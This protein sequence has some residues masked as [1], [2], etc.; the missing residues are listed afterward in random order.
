MFLFHLACRGIIILIKLYDVVIV[1]PL[2]IQCDN[3]P[4]RQI[5]HFLS[6]PEG[7]SAARRPSIPADKVPIRF[8]KL[9]RRQIFLYIISQLN[10]F[11]RSAARVLIEYHSVLVCFPLRIKYYISIICRWTGSV[12]L[13]C[14]H[15]LLVRERSAAA[16]RPRIPAFEYP[17]SQSILVFFQSLLLIINEVLILH[18]A[19]FNVVGCIVRLVRIIF[20]MINVRRRM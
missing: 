13:L 1:L 16:V 10:R 15:D 5:H 6:V 14:C 17:A 12:P 9:I 4:C 7:L 2:S 19:S 20:D 11:H 18:H 3:A 8:I